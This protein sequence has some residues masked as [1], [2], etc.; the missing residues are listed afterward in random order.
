MHD[1]KY[2]K[3]WS[4]SFTLVISCAIFLF[5]ALGQSLVL[6]LLKSYS[7]EPISDMKML[8]YANLGLI[9]T[10]SSLLGLIVIISFIWMKKNTLKDYLHINVPSIRLVFIFLIISFILMFFME[11]LSSRFPNLFEDNFV[12]ASYSEANSLTLLYLGVVF[13]GPLFEE[14]LF[15]G[16]MFK[17]LENSF[18]GGTPI[19]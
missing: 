1:P 13:L 11:F 15:R 4:L 3:Y 2:Q 12:T 8:A 10:V 19:S 7:T 17:G 18:L 16:F 5:F 9:S 6:F 14:V